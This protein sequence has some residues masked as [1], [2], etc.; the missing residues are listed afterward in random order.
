MHTHMDI[1]RISHS[2]QAMLRQCG[3]CSKGQTKKRST[4]VLNYQI[5][6]ALTSHMYVKRMAEIGIRAEVGRADH[7]LLGEKSSG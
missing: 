7:D 6:I 1:N 4:R 5:Y 2:S 3:E